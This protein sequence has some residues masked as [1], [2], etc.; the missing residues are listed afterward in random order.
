MA[1]SFKVTLDTQV[2]GTA[3]LN[4]GDAQ[5]DSEQ[6]LLELTGETDVV[7]VKVWGDIKVGDPLNAAF[8]TSEE[9]A[10]WLALEPSFPVALDNTPG[11]KRLNV[12]FRD[13]VWN[14]V[15]VQAEI[16]FGSP[17]P[18]VPDV[19][20]GPGGRIARPRSPRRRARPE[21]RL[22]SSTT[23]LRVRD[24]ASVNSRGASRTML[25]PVSRV[26]LG[27]R[28]AQ[29]SSIDISSGQTLRVSSGSTGALHV[30]GRSRLKRTQVGP[31]MAAILD[32]LD[33][34]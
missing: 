6:V 1:S 18:F 29:R 2:S 8:G 26:K 31:E 21:R 15:T 11:L 4:G 13:D 7:E 24:H 3:R 34:L 30:D 9:A 25:S 27:G 5:T 20:P 33:L 10:Q 14:E 17:A 28:Q 12:V 16:V 32:L 19:R 23:S 22:V